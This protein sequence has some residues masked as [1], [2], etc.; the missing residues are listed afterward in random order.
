MLSFGWGQ[1]LRHGGYT[2]AHQDRHLPMQRR[3]PSRGQRPR[4]QAYAQFTDNRY[5]RV[6]AVAWQEVS[7]WVLDSVEAA[8]LEPVSE[9]V[10]HPRPD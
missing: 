5:S 7:R 3:A 10:F 9:W 4:L 6:E 8:R 2:R 1:P